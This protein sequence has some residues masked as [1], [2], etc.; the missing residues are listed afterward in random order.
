VVVYCA[1]DQVFAEPI[2]LKFGKQTRIK[3]KAVYDS[4]A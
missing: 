1:Q 2:F 4:E 3:V